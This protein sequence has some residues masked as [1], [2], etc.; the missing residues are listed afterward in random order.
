MFRSTFIP[1]QD[2][3]TDATM[4]VVPDPGYEKAVWD[5]VINRVTKLERRMSFIEGRGSMD[6]PRPSKS[7][8]KKHI[9]PLKLLRQDASSSFGENQSK[10]KAIYIPWSDDDVGR[11]IFTPD[12][13]TRGAHHE[14]TTFNGRDYVNRVVDNTTFHA[15]FHDPRSPRP[16]LGLMSPWAMPH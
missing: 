13:T 3:S 4:N 10:D 14:L 5:A 12:Q 1:S 9:N 2:M 11:S 6:I 15:A 7:P 8:V 16:G